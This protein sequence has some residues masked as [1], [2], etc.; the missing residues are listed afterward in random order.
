MKVFKLS[1]LLSVIILAVACREEQ[2]PAGAATTIAG[3]PA[4]A[5]LNERIA[6]AP[7]QAD[8]YAARAE[9]YYERDAFDEAIQDLQTA[10]GLDSTQ[11][12]YYHLLADVYLDYFRSRQALETMQRAATLFPERIPTLLKLSEFQYILK[13]YEESMRTIDRVLR[14]DPQEPEAY[15]MFGLNFRE[16]G[17]TTRAI[18]SFQEAVDINP[19]LTDAWINLGQLHAAQRSGQALRY[20][21]AAIASDTLN[22]LPYAAK[23]DYLRDRDR[24]RE[25]IALYK[26]AARKDPQYDAAFFN[27]GLLYLELDSIGP[28]YRQFDLAIKVAPLNIQ[29]YFFRGYAAEAVG[30]T[31]QA[32]RDYEHALRLAPDYELPREGLA[33][34]SD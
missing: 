14:I 3:E 30:D 17:D 32:R 10:L 28:A 23:G 24:L 5:L 22:P 16:V 21:D 8:L 34:L 13:Q 7:A 12:G 20:F 26:E 1:L 33:R 18:R 2:Q 9:L 29:A 6:Q 4:I 11:V 15:F 25:A 27:A 31:L 19:T